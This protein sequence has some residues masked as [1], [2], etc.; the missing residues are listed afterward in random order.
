MSDEQMY[1]RVYII[2]STPEHK[3][4]AFDIN[5]AGQQVLRPF[6]LD[7]NQITVLITLEFTC[8]SKKLTYDVITC[9]PRRVKEGKFKK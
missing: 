3:V 2:A 5:A 6:C 9:L 8:T 1:L 7:L 4:R